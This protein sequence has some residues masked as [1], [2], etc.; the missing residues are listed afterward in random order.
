MSIKQTYFYI[1]REKIKKSNIIVLVGIFL[2]VISSIFTIITNVPIIYKFIAENIFYKTYKLNQIENLTVGKH[3]N[4]YIR[5]FG[6]PLYI[7]DV[8]TKIDKTNELKE[9][10]FIDKLFF[11]DTII[12]KNGN[13]VQYSVT[14]RDKD[15]NPKFIDQTFEDDNRKLEVKLGKTKF[16]ELLKFPSHIN[17]CVGAHNFYY[18]ESIYHGNPGNYQSYAFG[19]NES[20]YTDWDDNTT[21][22]VG[23][24]NKYCTDEPEDHIVDKTSSSKEL[25]FMRKNLTINTY[26]VTTPFLGVIDNNGIGPD[27]NRV[28]IYF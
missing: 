24:I 18:F 27:Y 15:F 23:F 16:S 3:I 19:I 20:G 26:L 17:G 6:D 13:V 28:R 21:N 2:V 5:Q 8:E 7:E 14:T 11:L 25:E 4:S 10:V 22:M 12:D 1:L 9:Y